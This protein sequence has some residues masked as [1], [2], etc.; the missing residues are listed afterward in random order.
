[1]TVARKTMA[2]RYATQRSRKES[3]RR[4]LPRLSDVVPTAVQERESDD[5][6]EE[7]GG[8]VVAE[9]PRPAEAVERRVP[10]QATAPSRRALPVG[11]RGLVVPAPAVT[12][13]DY[14]YV[15]R[16]LRRIALTAVVMLVLLVV[17]NIVL[18]Q[19]IH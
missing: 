6:P 13:V 10:G 1:V 12:H 8:V 19:L 11:R 4:S 14:S 17:L 7:A 3:R 5:A 16:D 18:Q 2:E 15:K 9:P